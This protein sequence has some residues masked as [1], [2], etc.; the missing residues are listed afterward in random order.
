MEQTDDKKLIAEMDEFLTDDAQTCPAAAADPEDGLPFESID[1]YSTNP[2]GFE[3]MSLKMLTKVEAVFDLAVLYNRHSS[4]YLKKCAQLEKGIK[5]L[6]TLCYTKHALERKKQTFPSL[7]QLSTEKLYCMA[8]FHFEKLDRALSEYIEQKH[9]IDDALLDMQFRYFSLLERIRS[10]E[11]KLHKYDDCLYYGQENYDPVINGFAFSEKSWTKSCH[12]TEHEAPAFRHSPAFPLPADVKIMG[13]ADK[14]RLP[15][16]D[17]GV[18]DQDSGARD[19]HDPSV[20]PDSENKVENGFGTQDSG[21][22]DS[23]DPSVKP[24]PENKVEKGFGTQDSGGRDSQ[25]PS[26][27]P[28]PENKVE[29]GFGTQ[30]SGVR[31]SDPEDKNAET[32]P[33]QINEVRADDEAKKMH[34]EQ[35]S[36]AESHRTVSEQ[37]HHDGNPE[38]DTLSVTNTTEPDSVPESDKD[39]DRNTEHENSSDEISDDAVIPLLRGAL[40][41]YIEVMRNV[42]KRSETKAEDELCFSFDELE[43]LAN[44]PEFNYFEPSLAADVRHAL[45]RLDTG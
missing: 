7:G 20:K 37:M 35:F 32:K 21:G 43:F 38:A 25:N 27:D 4:K 36:K 15:Q 2:I 19:S 29:K 1:S 31:D 11:V 39:A 10:T 8:S 42:I 30:D 24:D 22:R 3:A 6:G 13:A 41:M 5:Y 23:H 9:E 28:D 44:D 40:P 14:P 17:K 26:V 12:D 34:R 45:S 33:E 16:G 18:R